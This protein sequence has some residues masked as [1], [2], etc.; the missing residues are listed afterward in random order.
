[1]S[2]TSSLVSARRYFLRTVYSGVVAL[3]LACLPAAHAQSTNPLG[4]GTARVI[5]K[6]K[7]ASV[8]SKAATMGPATTRASVLSKRFSVAMADGPALAE[9]TQVVT[10]RDLTSIELAQRLARDPDVE[11]AVPDRRRKPHAAPNDP[12]YGDGVPGNGPAVG[13]WYL[14]A[15]DTVVKA[16]LDIERAWAV[17]TGNPA[18]VVAVL[19]TGL[20]FDHPD[21]AGANVLAGYDMVSN[22]EPANDGD[23]RDADA[24]DPGDWVTEAEAESGEFSDCDVTNSTWHGTQVAGLIVAQTDNGTGMASIARS[25][26]LLPVRVLGK[27]GGFDSDII[28]GI[29]WAAGLNVPGVPPNTNPARV[30]NLSLG[31]ESGCTIAYEQAIAQVNALGAV[32]VAS[33]GNSAGHATGT[34]ANCNGA[35]AVAGLRHVGTKVGFSDLGSDIAVSAPGGNCINITPGSPCLYPILSTSNAGVTT[36]GE[37]IFTDSFRPTLGTSFSA[38]LVAGTVALILS[39][40]PALTP[41]QVRL[42]LQATARPF[43]VT[44]GDNGDGTIVPQ[45]TAPQFNTAG[46]PIDQLQCYCT[47][48]TCGAGVLDA[49]AAVAGARNGLAAAGVAAQGL[50]WKA[51]AAS[52]S[53]WGIN[54]AHQGQVVFATWFTYDA[55]GRA[56][57][58]SMTANRASLAPD[59]YTGTLFESAGPP[60][61][62]IPFDPNRVTRTPVG[63]ATLTFNDLN[64]ATFSYNVNG[65]QQSKS[66][67][68]VAF[69]AVPQCTYVA[70]PDFINAANFQDLWWATGGTEAGWGVNLTHQGEVIFAT[71]FTYD[72]DGKPLWLSATA[73]QTAPR[74]YAGQ[75]VRSTGPSFAAVPFDPAAVSRTTV[76]AATF[77]FTN[78]NEGTFTYTVNG[79]T[80]VK[81]ITR[82]L[83]APPASTLCR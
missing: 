17:T 52:E 83:F 36:P 80:Q 1:M 66:I 9:D 67:T 58:L 69:G 51:P 27:C 7:A 4:P 76:G 29:R 43:P 56:W 39:A 35:I 50:W 23:G 20:R 16:S 78:G 75:L 61:N 73:P 59:V 11:Y 44:G 42:V 28:A 31:S 5:V 63:P 19:D 53:G 6:F 15:P 38:P 33:A 34:P 8:L 45:C 54:F 55:F 3:T 13:Q 26:R 77:A 10:S 68:R 18:I 71:W 49:G 47:I 40:Q 22:I 24:S 25:V 32:V 64:R 65:I 21:L 72:A 12:L 81:P 60:F 41:V 2:I 79:V 46:T 57:W 30:I 14:R 82:V 37:H 48:D 74:V 70:Q 62:S